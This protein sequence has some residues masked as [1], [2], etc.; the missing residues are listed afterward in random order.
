M[1][2]RKNC[3]APWFANLAIRP[4]IALCFS[5]SGIASNAS[6]SACA[7]S[8]VIGSFLEFIYIRLGLYKILIHAQSEH[9]AKDSLYNNLRML[10][11]PDVI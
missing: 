8:G 5:W 10:G 1:A 4:I 2:V 6:T 7:C 11:R 3:A 9:R